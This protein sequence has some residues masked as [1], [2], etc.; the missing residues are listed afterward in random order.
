MTLVRGIFERK[1]EDYMTIYQV[2]SINDN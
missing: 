2:V 1:R